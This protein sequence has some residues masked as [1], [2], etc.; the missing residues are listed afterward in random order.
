MFTVTLTAIVTILPPFCLS[1]TE[2]FYG[3]AV[4]RH[5]MVTTAWDK[6]NAIT[7]ITMYS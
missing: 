7:N 2:T 4:L 3:Y 1:V 6:K 5:S